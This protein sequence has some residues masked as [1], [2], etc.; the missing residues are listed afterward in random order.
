MSQLQANPLASDSSFMHLLHVHRLWKFFRAIPVALGRL[1]TGSHPCLWRR[2]WCNGFS[3]CLMHQTRQEC[4]TRISSSWSSSSKLSMTSWKRDF[5]PTTMASPKNTCRL[6]GGASATAGTAVLGTF[7]VLGTSHVH[8]LTAVLMSGYLWHE[9]LHAE[10]GQ[11][12]FLFLQGIS[13]APEG[14]RNSAWCSGAAVTSCWAGRYQ[15][16]NLCLETVPA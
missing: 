11:V 14:L 1:L 8:G 15:D 10:V 12:L 16:A 3:L 13:Q 6:C 2:L 5:L 7:H 4:R 9:A